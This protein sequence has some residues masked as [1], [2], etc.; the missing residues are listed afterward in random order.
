MWK[1]Y[2]DISS[3][4][5]K[6]AIQIIDSYHFIRQMVWASDKVRKRV[7]KIYG[8]EYRKLFKNSRLLLIKRKEQLERW[9]KERVEALLYVSDELLHA[10]YLKELFYQIIDA[11]V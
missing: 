5:F 1:P 3:A 6:N 10:Y 2:T 4:F 11:D 9:Q 7:Q 8:K